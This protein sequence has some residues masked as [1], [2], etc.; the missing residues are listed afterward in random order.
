MCCLEGGTAGTTAAAPPPPHRHCSRLR[1]TV[2]GRGANENFTHLRR[3]PIWCSERASPALWRNTEPSGRWSAKRRFSQRASFTKP[4]SN[5]SQ[6][7]LESGPIRPPGQITGRS[8]LSSVVLL[9]SARGEISCPPFQM[10][11]Q[12]GRVQ[13]L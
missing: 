7:G 4:R 12:G 8:S 6:T 5:Y 2:L 1:V 13:R 9:N 3:R 11:Q 10:N